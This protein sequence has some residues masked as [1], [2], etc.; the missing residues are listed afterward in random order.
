MWVSQARLWGFRFRGALYPTCR[1]FYGSTLLRASPLCPTAAAVEGC[2]ESL[3]ATR[4]AE[5][6]PGG[7]GA[8]TVPAL[9]CICLPTEHVFV[10]ELR[11]RKFEQALH[12]SRTQ[13]RGDNDTA[14]FLMLFSK[15]GDARLRVV[16]RAVSQMAVCLRRRSLA[17]P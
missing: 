10:F 11:V 3:I 5:C 14:R 9:V 16:S 2:D 8:L 4:L 1:D 15:S 12:L 17:N 13:S 7:R 6:S